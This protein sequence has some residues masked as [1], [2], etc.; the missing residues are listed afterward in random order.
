MS[1]QAVRHRIECLSRILGGRLICFLLLLVMTVSAMPG[2]KLHAHD[3]GA[4]SHGH[5]AMQVSG[6]SIGNGDHQSSP[7]LANDSPLHLH[8]AANPPPALSTLHTALPDETLPGIPKDR[9]VVPRQPSAVP[10]PP[11]RPPI[12]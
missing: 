7:A 11:Y 8:E 1:I 3:N 5:M 2:V 12:A 10:L 4:R 6:L 9:L